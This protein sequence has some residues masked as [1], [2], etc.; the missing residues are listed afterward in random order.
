M[1]D[2]ADLFEYSC[3]IARAGIRAQFPHAS[4]DEVEKELRRRLRI[5][6]ILEERAWVRE[7]D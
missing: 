1:L 7:T 3:E 5:G 6:D 2:G 4:A